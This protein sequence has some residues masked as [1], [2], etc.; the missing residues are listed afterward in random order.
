[1]PGRPADYKRKLYFTTEDRI[2]LHL[3]DFVGLD[4]EFDQPD[5]ITQFGIAEAIRLGRSTVSKAIRR[6]QKERLISSHRAHV[7]S[8][9]LRRTVYLLTDSGVSRANHRKMEIEE[10]IVSFRDGDGTARRLKVAQIPSLLPEYAT[11]LDVVAHVSEGAFEAST[12]EAG[13]GSRFVD[14]TERLPRLRYFFGRTDEMAAMDAWL[15]APAARVLVI[16]GITGIGKTT[17]LSRK[18]EDWR[19]RRHLSFHRIMEWTTLRN[20]VQQLAEFLTHL[21]RKQLAQYLEAHDRPEPSGGSPGREID[22]EQI[23]SILAQDLRDVTAVLVYDDYQNAAPPIRNFFYALRSVLETI[24][25]PRLIVA[26]RSVAPFYDR[27]EVRVKG[28]VQE[29]SLGGLDPASTEELLQTRNLALTPEALQTLYRQ[30]AGHPLFLELVDS[31]VAV[32]GADIHKYLEEELFSRITDVEAKVLTVASVFRYPVHV[33]ALFIDESVDATTIRGLTEQ[34]LLQEVSA[35][36]YDV[37]D[38]VRAF[39][40]SM[41]TPRDRRRYHRWAA[42]F[43]VSRMNPDPLEALHHFTEA[44]D[45]T[46]A[47]RVAVKEG[48][49]IL[50]GGRSEELLRLLDRL[51]PGVDDRAQSTELRLLKARALTVR[52]EVDAAILLYGEILLIPMDAALQPKVAEARQALGDLSRRHGRFDEAQAHLETALRL[53][54]DLGDREGQAETFLTLG[55]LAENSSDA[56]RAERYYERSLALAEALGKKGLEARLHLAFSR[57]FDLRGDHAAGLERKQRALDL[58]DALADWHLQAWILV[59]LGAELQ[60]LARTAESLQAY[61]RGIET[62]RRIGDLRILAYGLW[63]AAGAYVK[64]DELLRAEAYLKEAEGIFRKL[65]EPVMEALV[66]QLYGH[67]WE[68]R[69][70]WPLAKQQL[71]TAL[72][73]LRQWNA[74]ADFARY[75][76]VTAELYLRN[77]E[78]EESIVLLQEALAVAKRVR[79]AALVAEIEKTMKESS[80]AGTTTRPP[81]PSRDGSSTT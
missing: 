20:V 51:L 48:R 60:I 37:H 39:F 55:T 11:L 74:H 69:G 70:K 61:E 16:T 54:R 57:M 49:A 64:Q 67:V 32:E 44:E 38:V 59:V 76:A 6:L 22:I 27:R 25:G 15:D 50:A 19:G 34:S 2:L 77:G 36:V 13:G 66:L 1:V 45:V 31:A 52:G 81:A 63:N 71:T 3:L 35:R 40:L 30:T 14:L 80:E 75:A 46:S 8:G 5:A 41:M 53:Y 62:A 58:A 43:H 68:K 7:P 73:L 33:D 10:D 56:S 24:E 79:S 28:V 9:T 42:Q 29:L 72:N 26:G 78:R 4:G 21:S 17:L 23:A 18:V 47:A 12:F 65:K